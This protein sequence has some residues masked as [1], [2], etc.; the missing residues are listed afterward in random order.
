VREIVSRVCTRLDVLNACRRRDLG[1]VIA[2]L[3]AH[4][5]TQGQIAGLTGIPQGRLSEY[6]TGKYIPRAVG[7][8]EAFADGVGLP[9]AAR[10]A[11]GLAP[12]LSPAS[13]GGQRTGA[14]AAD[15]GLGYADEPAEVAGNLALR[16]EAAGR[17]REAQLLAWQWALANRSDGGS[18]AFRQGHWPT[19]LPSRAVGSAGQAVG[20]G[21][22]TG[23]A[24]LAQCHASP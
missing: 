1:A 16:G 12:E 4:G 17:G 23:S 3:N 6:K 5:V 18:L 2:T 11:L 14:P 22:R 9:R 15:V 10:E 20:V 7:I 13:A 24:D 19:A 8:F 21:W